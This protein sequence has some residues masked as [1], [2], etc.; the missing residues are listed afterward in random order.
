M[1]LLAINYR[2]T[3]TDAGSTFNLF[4]W[5]NSIFMGR[6]GIGLCNL[7]RVLPAGLSCRSNVKT[8]VCAKRKSARRLERNREEV[9][10]TSS[11]ADDN[12]QEVKMNSS[13]SSPKNYLINISS[14]SSVLQACI[15]TSG[16]IAA[17][18]VIIRQVS[19]VASIEGL[20]VIDCTSEVSFSF[21][22]WQLQLIIGLVV[23]I[24]S[25]RFF[26]LKTW[27]DFAESSEA[28]NRQVLT[29]LQPLDY[30]VVAFLPGIS[31]EL[32]FR[33]ALI[34]LLGFNW[35]S[36]VVT[37]AIFG[38]L[39]LGGGRKYSFAI[40]ATF[41]GLAYGYATIESSSIVVPMAS[42]ALNNLVGGILWTYESRSLENL[43]D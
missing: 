41:V 37:A 1:N 40:W 35:A 5:R 31:E 23:L 26:L 6:K 25:S 18:G 12:A 22:V 11:S 19:H 33:G 24:S 15:I 17:L 3:S 43:E 21:E 10:I 2:C 27:P 32:L 38:I 34:P 16:L 36:V 8:K 28:A 29:S 13:D 39:H 4:T 14:R 42:H 30:A 20:P 7:R 9:S